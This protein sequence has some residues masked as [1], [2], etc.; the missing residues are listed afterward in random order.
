MRCVQGALALGLCLAFASTLAPSTAAADGLQFSGRSGTQKWWTCVPEVGCRPYRIAATVTANVY[1]SSPP[2]GRPVALASFG[3]FYSTAA[4]GPDTLLVYGFE[5]RKKGG[6]WRQVCVKGRCL[7]DS[8]KRAAWPGAPAGGNYFEARLPI[9]RMRNIQQIRLLVKPLT[10][11]GSGRFVGRLRTKTFNVRYHRCE[12]CAL[13]S[14][15]P[16]PQPAPPPPPPPPAKDVCAG[17]PSD[18]SVVCVRNHGHT[19]DVCDRH[20]DGHRAYAR[21]ITEAS[22]PAFL[23]PYY[24]TNDSKPGC[25]NLNFPSRVL[26]VAACAQYEGCSA[27]RPAY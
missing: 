21:V 27:F 9:K 15:V 13:P 1:P 12:V 26:A 4:L 3:V 17:H 16:A 6:K 14:S 2:K 19:V 22:N 5:Y 23:S 20:A 25:A 11:T 7:F 10:E 24:D 18:P 8:R